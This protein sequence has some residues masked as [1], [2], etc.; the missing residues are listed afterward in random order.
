MLLSPPFN[1]LTPN[2]TSLRKHLYQAIE[3]FW[4][5]NSI[6]ICYINVLTNDKFVWHESCLCVGVRTKEND[7]P[8]SVFVC[9]LSSFSSDFCLF[10][11]YLPI[12]YINNNINIIIIIVLYSKRREAKVKKKAARLLNNGWTKANVMLLCHDD[13]H[14][15]IHP[16]ININITSFSLNII[17]YF[18]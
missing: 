9:L 5:F 3:P 2:Q 6:I 1:F 12:T 10:S 8:P 16:F 17:A 4:M 18:W 11:H 7:E 13:F 14:S 15:Y